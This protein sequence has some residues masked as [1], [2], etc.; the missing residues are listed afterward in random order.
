[1]T[2]SAYYE[3]S[4]YCSI[5]GVQLA[6]IRVKMI[7]GT[8][9]WL[10]NWKEATTKHPVFSLPPARL[11][12]LAR[13]EARRVAKNECDPELLQVC[14]LAILHTLESIKQD[15]PALPPAAIVETSLSRLFRLAFWKW[16]L[17][18]ERFKFP[19]LHISKLNGNTKFENISEYLDLCFAI[20]HEYETKINEIAEQAKI[21]AAER[22]M[23]A[24]RNNWIVPASK[25][26]LWKWVR[27]YID[28]KWSADAEGWLGTLFLG[29]DKAVLAFDPDEAKLAE[30]IIIG[31]CPA[32]TAILFAVRHRL[33]YISKLIQDNAE[34]FEVDFSDYPSAEVAKPEAKNFA[35]RADYIRANAIWYLQQRA[36]EVR[37]QNGQL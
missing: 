5:S 8:L 35:K 37:G 29:N 28:A 16:K 23:K 14:F 3:Q 21:D 27:A 12:A 31:E 17:E 20:K 11:F 10:S 25:K 4:L 6:T 19:T 36:K 34:A 7:A 32:G 2:Q 13:D 33:E 1:M 18:S 15:Q 22:A 24:L 30:D 9:P 26:A